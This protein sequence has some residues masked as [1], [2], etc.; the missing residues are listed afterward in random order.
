MFVMLRL[1]FVRVFCFG[2]MDNIG[3]LVICLI[4]VF[5]VF[6]IDLVILVILFVEF[7]NCFKLLLKILIVILVF[8]LEINL[9]NFI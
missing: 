6:C 3:R 9:L 2:N 5:E 1:Y 8:M 4:W 7:N